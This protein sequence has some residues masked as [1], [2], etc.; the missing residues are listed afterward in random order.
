[1]IIRE[2]H[3]HVSEYYQKV[4][5]LGYAAEDIHSLRFEFRY[6]EQEVELNEQFR[7]THHPVEVQTWRIQN[8]KRRSE[9]MQEVAAAIAG[10]FRCLQFVHNDTSDYWSDG[11]DYFFWCNSF[12]ERMPDWKNT[13]RDY[14]YFTL[15]FNEAMTP[16]KRQEICNQTLDFLRAQFGDNPNLN[17]TIQYQTRFEHEKINRDV[18]AVKYQL[19]NRQIDLDGKH[20]KIVLLN[21]RVYFKQKYAKKNYWSFTETELLILANDFGLLP[22]KTEEVEHHGNE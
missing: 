3:S 6:T 2:D 12:S 22:V 15:S 13:E 5:G 10:K 14:S 21:D 17:V 19:V 4:I 11:W 7:K 18:E 20:G 8:M 9:I 1:M 16:E